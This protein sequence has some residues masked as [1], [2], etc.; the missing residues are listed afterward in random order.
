MSFPA[1]DYDRL[2]MQAWSAAYAAALPEAMK[3]GGPT[4]YAG[5]VAVMRADECV[6][7]FDKR[8]SYV[9]ST[10]DDEQ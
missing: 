10:E 7:R 8:W 5:L 9:L 1:E 4:H 2:L 3:R 6:E